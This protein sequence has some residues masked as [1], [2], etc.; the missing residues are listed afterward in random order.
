MQYALLIYTDPEARD[1]V[2]PEPGGAFEDWASFFQATKDA[3][4]FLA[5]EGLR[6]V[7]TA[8]T[9]RLSAGEL[10]LTDGPFADTKEHLLGF[11]L[12]DAP[13]LDA[14]I[15]WAGRM[16]VLRRG[17]VEIRPLLPASTQVGRAWQRATG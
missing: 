12:I 5:A 16:P 8:T 14:A 1:E 10:L 11:F 9:V 2:G 4:V 17:A 15:G 6:D 13:N 3:G 7:D